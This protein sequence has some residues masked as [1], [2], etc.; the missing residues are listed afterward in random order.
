MCSLTFV[1]V[2]NKWSRGYSKS[3]CL[4]VEYV[5]LA[6]LPCL[7]SVGKPHRDLKR[8]VGAGIPRRTPTCPEEKEWGKDCGKG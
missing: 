5:L 8:E 7:A 3:Y 4:Y 2:L 1:W 6:G